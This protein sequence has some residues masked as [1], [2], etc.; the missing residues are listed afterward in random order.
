MVGVKKIQNLIFILF[1]TMLNLDNQK[2]VERNVI[3][4]KNFY[5]VSFFTLS[6]YINDI[7]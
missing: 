6:I 1:E 4:I 3:R 7:T 2:N 5:S